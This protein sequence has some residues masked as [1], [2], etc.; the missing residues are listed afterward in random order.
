MKEFVFR[1]VVVETVFIKAEDENEACEL[2]EEAEL[3]ADYTDIEIHRT[4]ENGCGWECEGMSSSA[5]A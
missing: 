1:R 5:G 4:I 2:L 3:F